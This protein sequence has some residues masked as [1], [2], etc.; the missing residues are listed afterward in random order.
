MNQAQRPKEGVSMSRDSDVA[1]IPRQ[2]RAGDVA[3]GTFEFAAVDAFHHHYGKP[4]SW[5]LE[6]A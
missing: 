2:S 5:N 6:A 3:D 1:P 4:E